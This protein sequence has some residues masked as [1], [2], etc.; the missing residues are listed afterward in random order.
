MEPVERVRRVGPCRG[1]PGVRGVG[2]GQRALAIDRQPGVQRVV[3]ALGGGEVRLGQLVRRDLA[4]RRSAA[5]SWACRRVRSVIGRSA[6]VEDR[7]GR[8]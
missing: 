4:L 5:I 1:K 8:R 7:P 6:L 3:L 2:L